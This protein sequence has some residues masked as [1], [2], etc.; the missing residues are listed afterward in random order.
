MFKRK[1]KKK[2][3]HSSQDYVHN[4][5]S[6]LQRISGLLR[7]PLFLPGNKLEKS[8][9]EIEVNCVFNF[10]RHTGKN[11]IEFSATIT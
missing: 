5:G 7:Q 8:R 9:L 11:T 1:R 6:T 2:E 4:V 3:A 10:C